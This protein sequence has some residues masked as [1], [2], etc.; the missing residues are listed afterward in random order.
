MLLTHPKVQSVLQTIFFF[1]IITSFANNLHAIQPEAPAPQLTQSSSETMPTKQAVSLPSASDEGKTGKQPVVTQETVPDWKKPITKKQDGNG[2]PVSKAPNSDSTSVSKISNDDGAPINLDISQ[3]PLEN[4]VSMLAKVGKKTILLGQGAKGEKIQASFK[5]VP[6]LKALRQL[7]TSQNLCVVEVEDAL[8]LVTRQE[9]MAMYA[10][11][12]VVPLKR[13][14]PDAVARLLVSPTEKGALLDVLSDTRARNLVLHG[15]PEQI[16]EAKKVAEDLDK[17]LTKKIFNIHY[18]SAAVLADTIKNML[19]GGGEGK[20]VGSIVLDE[21]SNSL[22]IYET[23]ENLETCEGIISSFDVRVESRVFSVGKL[24]PK[25][26]ASQISNGEFTGAASSQASASKGALSGLPTGSTGGA[27]GSTGGATGS[28]GGMS[29]RRLSSGKNASTALG[30]SSTNVQVVDGTNQIVV[31][32][33][34]ERLEIL[35]KVMEELNSNVGT[36]I[37]RPRNALPTDVAT[38]LKTSFPEAVATVD[39]RTGS[40]IITAHRDR[41][42]EIEALVEKVDKDEN[43]EIDIAAK[44]MLVSTSKLKAY[45][46]RIY[47]ESFGETGETLLNGTINPN[48]LADATKSVGSSLGNPTDGPITNPTK[49]SS[50]YLQSLQPNIQAQALVRA[51]ASDSDTNILS[52]PKLRMMVGKTSTI[53]SGAKEPYTETT[54]TDSST[55]ESVKF[56]DTGVTLEVTPYL[57]PDNLLTLDVSTNFS[58]LREYINSVPVVETRTVQTTVQTVSGD[59]IFLGG[60]IN[61][62]DTKSKS[63]IPV[64]RSI[65]G[66]GVLFGAKSGNAVKSELLVVLTPNIVPKYVGTAA[67]K[68]TMTEEYENTMKAYGDTI[69]DNKALLPEKDA[70]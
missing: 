20:S 5:D 45:G 33:T 41:L 59:T 49:T 24:D 11:T 15:S 21:R 35:A 69:K 8:V 34:P 43:V 19:Q 66:L 27:T 50:N 23:S 62:T 61:Q 14:N 60:L 32:D 44:I 17:N 37:L 1:A 46:V 52:N 29:S 51:I 30:T 58:T 67:L 55:V 39:S 54:T 13:A 64:L 70:K 65:P 2:A 7:A 22:I 63:G 25:T 48:F 12:E 9:Y 47:G 10:K 38:L 6:F 3:Q 42:K 56:T 36:T 57:Q 68:K 26:V 16:Q 53:F 40:I 28:T 18:A 31:T 4:A